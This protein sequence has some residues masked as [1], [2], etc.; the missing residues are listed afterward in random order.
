VQ[1]RGEAPPLLAEYLEQVIWVEV[2]RARGAQQ[3]RAVQGRSWRGAAINH[4]SS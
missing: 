1:D 4:R 2:A 3:Q